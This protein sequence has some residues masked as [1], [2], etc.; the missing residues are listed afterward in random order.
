MKY[1]QM[2]GKQR[3]SQRGASLVEFAIVAPMV[4]LLG[5]GALQFALMFN[6]R[7][8]LN[9]ASFM[10]ARAGAT[11]HALLTDA[12]SPAASI[13]GAYLRALAPLY[14]GGSTPSEVKESEDIA[15]EDLADNLKIDIINPTRE[16]F[17]DW[18][19]AALSTT[20]GKGKGPNGSNAAVIRNSGQADVGNTVGQASGQTLQEANLLKIRVTHGYKPSVPVIRRLL[21]FYYK[22]IHPQGGLSAFDKQLLANDRIPVVMQATVQMQSHPI[23]QDVM[24]SIKD[25]PINVDGGN[26]SDTGGG[27][28]G[29]SCRVLSCEEPVD[30]DAGGDGE[31]DSGC[32]TQDQNYEASDSEIVYFEFDSDV[33]TEAAM[34][35]LDDY[36]ESN[37]ELVFDAVE[38]SGFTDRQ[39]DAD[40]NLALSR[41]RALAVE[42][43]LNS[44]Q[45]TDK[46]IRVIA[47]GETDPKESSPGDDADP[48]VLECLAGNRRVVITLKSVVRGSSVAQQAEDDAPEPP[49]S[50]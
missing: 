49:V 33:L 37:K 27:G 47:K 5:M 19:D 31:T 9:H 24:V 2:A 38:I 1:K 4:T 17:Q 42:K 8:H 3:H 21:I 46:P 32:I 7:N 28:S 34:E 11:H 6:A 20:L 23:F 35:D 41:R 44:K 30:P 36:I 39:G 12:S 14:G 18:K 48:T 45:F 16:S 13:Q 22:N 15:K 26:G 10:A 29:G 50:P 43:Y 25:K 40:Y